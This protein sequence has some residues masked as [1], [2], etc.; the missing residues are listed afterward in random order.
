MNGPPRVG[1]GRRRAPAKWLTAWLVSA[2][3]AA[4]LDVTTGSLPDRPEL[5]WDNASYLAM[6]RGS[7]EDPLARRPPYCYR[8]LFPWLAA[9]L[10]GDE[11]VGFRMLA[12]LG[13]AVGG[14]GLYGCARASSL[15][16][17]LALAAIPL[18]LMA[19]YGFRCAIFDVLPEGLSLAL[20][21]WALYALLTDRTLLFIA[22]VSVGSLARETLGLLIVPFVVY[23]WRRQDQLR[24]ILIPTLAA[25]AAVVLALVFA[26]L[27][28]V[29]TYAFSYLSYLLRSTRMHWLHPGGPVR[30]ALA[31]SAAAGAPLYLILLHA[32]TTWRYLREETHWLA[33]VLAYLAFCYSVAGDEERFTSYLMPPILLAALAIVRDRFATLGRP[34]V[35][36][37]LA[38]LHAVSQ[39][40]FSPFPTDVRSM[41]DQS[42]SSMSRD[43]LMLAAAREA[44]LFSACAILLVLARR[45]ASP[46]ESG[47]TREAREGSERADAKRQ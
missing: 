42:A 5:R 46:V 10:P 38:I 32:R 30:F 29:P 33:Y 47:A 44:A 41:V 13:A 24:E 22:L 6:A 1:A 16:H 20:L 15:S 25:V 36:G 28:V 21:T 8:P 35:V 2:A 40:A 19:R 27:R 31:V 26:R 34:W 17:P 18:F 9:L 23:R 4:A 7:P 37:G 12:V 3:C 39:R 11:R 43:L 45:T 14:A